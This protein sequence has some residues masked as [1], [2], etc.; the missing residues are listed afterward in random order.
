MATP[1]LLRDAIDA[2]GGA[3]RWNNVR[4]LSLRIRIRGTI[5]ALRLQ[6]PRLRSLKVVVDTRRIHISLDPFLRDGLIGVFDGESMRIETRDARVV[7]QRV[8]E[9]T[10]EG[11]IKRRLIW[12]DLDVLYFIGYA[13]WNYSVTP[14]LFSWDGFE[15]R[16]GAPI[17]DRRGAQLRALHVTY[18]G[19]F[20]AH[21]R[22]QTLYFDDAGLLRRLDY[23]A[24][25][26][27]SW[28]RAVHECESHR[29]FAGLVFPTHRS[30]FVRLPSHEPLRTFRMMEGWIDHVDL[31]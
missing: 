31:D 6:S 3:E 16:E 7:S 12:D 19:G 15:C 4:R 14:F 22:E 10:S 9:R 1:Q 25:V 5:L 18:P 21:S 13:L 30:V 8:I 20:P 17:L 24:D 23:S 29:T 28:A 2:H 27:A 26:F 11:D